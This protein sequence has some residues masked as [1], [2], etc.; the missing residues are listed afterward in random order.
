MQLEL[1]S[2]EAGAR[3]SAS[4]IGSAGFGPFSEEKYLYMEPKDP[5]A[6]DLQDS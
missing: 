6:T 5:G 4:V 2:R 1:K 3:F